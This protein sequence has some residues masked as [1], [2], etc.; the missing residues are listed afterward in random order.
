ME[1]EEARVLARV[2]Q[3]AEQEVLTRELDLR[4]MQ[5]WMR[6]TPIPLRKKEGSALASL[7]PHQ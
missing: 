4:P 3:A 5:K 1:A 2:Q 6:R 7:P